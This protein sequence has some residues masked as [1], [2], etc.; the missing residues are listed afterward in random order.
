MPVHP[1]TGAR[2]SPFNRSGAALI[3]FALTA[4]ILVS[5]LLG[6]CDLAPTLMA[7]F[8]VGAATQTVAD[9]ATQSATMQ[10]SDITDYFASGADVMAP[11]SG[12]N[13][14]F[15]VS[16]IAS[17]G[18]GNAFVYWSCGQGMKPLDARSA[19][20]STPTGTALKNLVSLTSNGTNTSY[21]MAESQYTYSAPAGFVLPS[22]QIMTGVAY[23]MPRVSTY[24]GPTTGDP[25]YV[26]ASPT[27]A[28]NIFSF[29]LGSVNCN[30]SY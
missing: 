7:K 14:L 30:V 16:N 26:P 6:V 29:N 18:N 15:R 22:A 11:F 3:E 1:R 13:L 19:V 23:T 24:I 12:T 17:D 21:V 25:N 8:K 2:R 9:L 28:R 10:T 27:N 20:T 5:L 4:P